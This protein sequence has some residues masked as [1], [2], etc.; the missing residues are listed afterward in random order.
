MHKI[1]VSTDILF[2]LLLVKDEMGRLVLDPRHPYYHQVQAAIYFTGCQAAD[3]LVWTPS[4][5]L[6]I[7]IG[8]DKDWEANIDRLK[9]FFFSEYIASFKTHILASQ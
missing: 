5:F 8:K 9:T 6:I 2:S 3:F 4:A 1:N 7:R